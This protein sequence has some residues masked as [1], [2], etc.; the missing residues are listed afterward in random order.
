MIKAYRRSSK[1]EKWVALK[2]RVRKRDKSCR[3]LKL[4]TVKEMLMIQRYAPG[5]LLATYDVAH[6]MGCGTYPHM[7]YN[8][9]NCILLNRYSHENLDNYKSPITGERITSEEVAKWWE[10]L[11]GEK[12]YE[13]LRKESLNIKEGVTNEIQEEACGS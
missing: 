3:L 11:I 13:C 6:V 1:D 4:L 8:D 7:T 5:K 2:E 12:L 10:R 9:K